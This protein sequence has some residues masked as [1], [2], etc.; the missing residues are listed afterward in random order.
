MKGKSDQPKHVLRT[1]LAE[2]ILAASSQ[3]TRKSKYVFRPA[4]FKED[5]QPLF[6][7]NLS[8]LKLQKLIMLP[9]FQKLPTNDLANCALVCK[10][11]K[12][13]L[14]DPSVWNKVQFESWKITSHILSLIVQR[15]PVK[16]SLNFCTISK[17]QLTWLLPRIPQTR[18]ISF[19]GIDFPS[20][21][22][23]LASVNTPTLNEL[24]LSFVTAF[25]DAALFKI[26]SS[27]RDSRPGTF[28]TFVKSRALLNYLFFSFQD[29]WIRNLV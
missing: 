1:Q 12:Q 28:G 14:Q 27:P 3:E 25:N 18:E 2:Q 13:I 24:D 4:P 6:K 7:M 29:S 8:E 21:L 22:L 5:P 16:L 20:C 26:L 10:S 19:Q 9:V 17:Q 15:Q 23:A 11:W